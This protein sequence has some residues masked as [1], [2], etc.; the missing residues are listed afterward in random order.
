M[1][2]GL[3]PFLL[4]I[5]A[6]AVIIIFCCGA[7]NPQT[8]LT[9]HMEKIVSILKEHGDDTNQAAS[10]LKEYVD[11]NLDTIKNIMT[12]IEENNASKPDKDKL[13]INLIFRHTEIIKNL[14]KL[15]QEKPALMNDQKVKE[16]LKP[17]FEALK[18]SI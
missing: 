17:L 1:K 18:L 2:R 6:L 10:S 4:I 15:E 14:K 12:K 5:C 16:A 13:D 11:N 7:A 9:T 3:N 8:E